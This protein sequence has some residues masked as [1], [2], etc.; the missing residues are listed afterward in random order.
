MLQGIKDYVKCAVRNKFIIGSYA[1]I[2]LSFLIKYVE[3]ETG[4]Q[5]PV[6]DDLLYYSGCI[7]LGATKFGSETFKAYR[8]MKEHIAEHGIIEPRF[9]DK[10]SLM[11]CTQT[12]IKMAAEEAGLENLI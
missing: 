11:Y 10:F 9:K 12:G 3:H 2:V 6:V 4:T 8:R 1:G 7:T 5:I